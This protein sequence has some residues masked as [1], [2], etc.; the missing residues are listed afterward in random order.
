MDDIPNR[1]QMVERLYDLIARQK[2]YEGAKTMNRGSARAKLARNRAWLKVMEAYD[3][4]QEAIQALQAT[5]ESR[6]ETWGTV[7]LVD[8]GYVVVMRAA[9]GS[10]TKVYFIQ[11]ADSQ[12][13]ARAFGK[14]LSEDTYCK[15]FVCIFSLPVKVENLRVE[16]IQAIWNTDPVELVS[17][18]AVQLQRMTG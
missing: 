1:E 13:E 3:L 2:E 7:K 17:D 5:A 6:Q 11:S 16:A 10:I 4:Q 18:E 15:P 8:A 12:E 14:K 9:D